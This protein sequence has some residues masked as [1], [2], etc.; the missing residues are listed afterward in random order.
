M[1]LIP[2]GTVKLFVSS[3]V[4]LCFIFAQA[5]AIAGTAESDN[6]NHEV[7]VNK[8]KIK[9]KEDEI[10]VKFKTGISEEKKSSLHNKHGAKKIKDFRS[11]RVEHVKLKKGMSVEEAIKSYKADPDVE[12]AEPNY[13]VSVQTIPNDTRFSELWGLYNIGWCGGT[14][15]VDIR[16][17]EAWDITTGSSDVVVAVIDTGVDYNHED[18]AANIWVNTAEIP[19]NGIDDDG[20]GYI[21]DIYGIDTY[22]HDTNPMDDYNHGTHVSGTIGAVGN[23]NLG[24]AGINW[25]VKIIGCKSI[26]ASGSG[27]DS[28]VIECL[29]YIRALKDRGVNIIATNNSWGCSDCYSSALYDAINAQRDILFIAAAGN[30]GCNTD[31]DVFYPAGYY[32]PNILSV[33]STD[34]TDSLARGSNYGRRSVHLGAPG[35]GIHSTVRNNSYGSYEGTSMAASHVTGVAALLKSHS[36][37]RGPYEI[38]NLLLSGGED[39]ASM[40]ENTITGKRLDAYGSLTCTNSPFFS[41]LSFPDSPQAGVSYTLSALSINCESPIG[42]V[43]VNISGAP[44][45]LH[46]DG[47]SPDLESGDGIFTG[48]WTP[49]SSEV[50]TLA[51]SSPAGSETIALPLITITGTVVDLPGTMIKD[52]VVAAPTGVFYRQTFSASGGVAPLSWS[53]SSGSLPSGLSIN[54]ST[55]EISGTPDVSVSPVFTVKVTDGVG[56]WDKMKLNLVMSTGLRSGWPKELQQ[57]DAVIYSQIPTSPVMAD[58]DGDGKDEIVVADNID[59]S[60]FKTGGSLYVLSSLGVTK[61][62]TLL[63]P[64]STPALADL[65]ADGDLE[66]I[67]LVNRSSLDYDPKIYAFHHDLTPV[68]G[69]PAN[70]TNLLYPGWCSTPVVSDLQNDGNP[71]IMTACTVNNT[72]DPNYGKYALFLLDTQGNMLPGWPKVTGK[73][74]NLFAVLMPAVGDL[75]SDGVKEVVFASED[76]LLHMFHKDGT[77]VSQWRFAE[78]MVGNVAWLLSDWSPIL[79]DMNGDGYLE[80]VLLYYDGATQGK[81]VSVFDRFGSMLNGWP[82]TC[83]DGFDPAFAVADLDQDGLPEVI[84]SKYA[85]GLQALR[86]DGTSLP[87]WPTSGFDNGPFCTNCSL[88]VGDV[89]GDGKMEVVFATGTSSSSPHFLNAITSEGKVAEGFPKYMASGIGLSSTP[90]L[91]DLDSN[92]KVDIV[93]RSERGLLYTWESGQQSDNIAFEWPM[94]RHDEKNTGAR[95]VS[96]LSNYL[97]IADGVLPSGSVGSAYTRTFTATGGKA[98]Y[99]WTVASGAL[100]SGVTLNSST[101]AISGMPLSSGAFGFTIQVTDANSST[102]LKKFSITIYEQLLVSTSSLPSAAIGAAYNQTLTASGGHGPYT[103]RISAGALPDGLD[104]SSSGIITGVPITTGSYAFTVEVRDANAATASKP[105]SIIVACSAVRIKGA[106]VRYFSSPQT[107]CQSAADGETIEFLAQDFSE[108][109]VFD[110]SVTATLKGGFDCGFTDAYSSTAIVGTLTIKSGTVLVENIVIK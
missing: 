25:N 15:G 32:L 19:G 53:I 67:V 81:V 64:V 2:K 34:N 30:D 24:V 23:N 103:W 41:V 89:T 17:P 1:L 46:D 49:A 109:L 66:I 75:D 68:A 7:V 36:P 105:L 55:G 87:G 60:N 52:G 42:P 9:Y 51:F 77:E 84:F 80:I 45:T 22:N 44:L 16:A 74:S 3:L 100:P 106:S 12:Y 95:P 21:D 71:V 11:L 72:H 62:T 82:K 38:K 29:Q 88:V 108:N 20:N 85:G 31:K 54:S 63:G 110:R 48:T 78:S 4:I 43:N 65:D 26:S 99:S 50:H 39:I 57:K 10:L 86:Y 61:Q 6:P 33:A 97:Q 91:G 28:G 69:F 104:L 40:D 96:P 93:F 56:M 101:G 35:K 83:D 107:A 18:L 92:R 79:A 94:V 27:Y 5:S 76:G 70:A 90:A 8:D 102:S 73:Q 13:V 58:L 59:T 47:V 98:P 37:A 14:P